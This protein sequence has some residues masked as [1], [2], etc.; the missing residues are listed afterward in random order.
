MTGTVV[1]TYSQKRKWP[2]LSCQPI[3]KIC[4]FNS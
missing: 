3:E 1:L 2:P 4:I